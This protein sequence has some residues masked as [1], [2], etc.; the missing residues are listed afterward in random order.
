[1]RTNGPRTRPLFHPVL[2]HRTSHQHFLCNVFHPV[3]TFRWLG[4]SRRRNQ[5]VHA[6]SGQCSGMMPWRK[7]FCQGS[8]ITPIVFTGTEAP[9]SS[10]SATMSR[11]MPSG[12]SDDNQKT[13]VHTG[14]HTHTFLTHAQHGP[15]TYEDVSVESGTVYVQCF[16]QQTQV[17]DSRQYRPADSF[18]LLSADWP[19]DFAAEH[20]ECHFLLIHPRINPLSTVSLECPCRSQFPRKQHLS[21]KNHLFTSNEVNLSPNT[22]PP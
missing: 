22:Q 16:C 9:D 18:V 13:S 7:E 11:Q 17:V 10:S 8:L 3:K 12:L 4:K 1:M 15:E 19:S 6:H 5:S 20:A 14:A 2:L 21:A